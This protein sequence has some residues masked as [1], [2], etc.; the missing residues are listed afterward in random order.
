M[1]VYICQ[2]EITVAEAPVG[3]FLLSDGTLICKS[4]YKIN[5]HCDCIIVESGEHYRGDG[6]A[7]KGNSIIVR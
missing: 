6:D 4:E 5:N 7:A 3:L 1:R 2:E